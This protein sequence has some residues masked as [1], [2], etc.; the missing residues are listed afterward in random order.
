MVA[1]AIMQLIIPGPW[2]LWPPLFLRQC[3]VFCLFC[4]VFVYINWHVDSSSVHE[5]V[6]KKHT[7]PIF[8]LNQP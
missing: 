3:T 8:I 5:M 1:I 6:N 7:V 2:P 4:F